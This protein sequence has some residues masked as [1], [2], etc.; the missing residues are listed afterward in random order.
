MGGSNSG[1]YG[2][3]PTIESGLT[4]D[5]HRLIRQGLLV[6]GRYRRGSIVWTRVASD[7]QVGSVGYEARMEGD[8]GHVRLH[9]ATTRAYNGDRR[10]LDYAITLETTLQPF[11]GRRWWF[12]CPMTGAL[13]F[14]SR[15]A[16][17][18][19]YRSKRET[20]RDRA[21]SR[22]FKLRQR[23]GGNGGIGDFIP[24]PKWLRWST[25]NR[26]MAGIETAERITNLHMWAL[27]E[28][29]NHKHYL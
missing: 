10:E 22:A 26:Q 19:G 15:R 1:R 6:P 11:G 13:T 27:V 20:A 2:G 5:L 9:Y 17:R 16:Y 18:L 4:L 14:A 29:F 23:L 12:V 8:C 21:L 24:K 28:K 3:R 7:E 25:F